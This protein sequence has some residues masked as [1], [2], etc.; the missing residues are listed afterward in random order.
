MTVPRHLDLPA[1]ERALREVQAHFDSMSRD[2]VETRDPFSDEVL[3]N[4]LAGYALIDDYVARDVDLF[5][6]RNIDLM[7]EINATVLCGVDPAERRKFAEHLAATERHFFE[8]EG[9]GIRDIL[10]WYAEHRHE[11]PWKRAAGIYVRILSKP[12]LFIEGNNRSGALIVSYLLLRA[13]LPPFVLTLANAA[14]YFNPSSVIRNSAKHGVRALFELPKIKKKFAAFL[15][16]QA[17]PAQ[18]FLVAETEVR[19]PPLATLSPL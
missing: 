14:G 4:I 10:E 11:S 5:E 13:G 2:F 1:I 6:L 3:S 12:Q 19:I 8:N 16:E 17:V 18:K 15:E 9:G 7:L